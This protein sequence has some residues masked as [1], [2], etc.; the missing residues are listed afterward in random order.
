[1]CPEK[2]RLFRVLDVRHL[3]IVYF[4][5]SSR[6]F[7]TIQLVDDYPLNTKPFSANNNAR[8]GSVTKTLLGQAILELVDKGNL[9][10]SDSWSKFY[11]QLTR[12]T[13]FSRYFSRH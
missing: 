11:S 1:M 7:C 12:L 9:S 10:L 2:A 5:L 4:L 13:S 3:D 8:V 6:N